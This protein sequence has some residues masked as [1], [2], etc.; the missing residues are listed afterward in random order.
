[1]TVLVKP[2]VADEVVVA[3]LADDEG[4]AAPRYQR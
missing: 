1:M 4:Q 2:E 3:L